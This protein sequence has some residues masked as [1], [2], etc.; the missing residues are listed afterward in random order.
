MQISSKAP[1]SER[2]PPFSGPL[3]RPCR[4][5]PPSPSPLRR[6]DLLFT[7]A[8][9]LSLL[10][11]LLF[12]HLLARL[13]IERVRWKRWRLVFR[14]LLFSIVTRARCGEMR[15]NIGRQKGNFPLIVRDLAY[16]KEYPFQSPSPFPTASTPSAPTTPSVCS[17]PPDTG[18]CT[19]ARIMWYDSDSDS[20]NCYDSG[21]PNA[22]DNRLSWSKT[23]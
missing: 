4:P 8:R 19:R 11:S 14:A 15:G 5:S 22:S 12:T 1:F 21:S 20:D 16:K 23:V 6:Y 9:N 7:R 2:F 10:S 17:L 3:R 18:P 13:S